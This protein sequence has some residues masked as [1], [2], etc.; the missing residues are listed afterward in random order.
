LVD[1]VPQTL[2]LKSI[3]TEFLKH[4]EIVVRRRTAYEL[5]RAEEREHILLGLVIALDNIDR[6]IK[7]IRASKTVDDARTNLMKEFKLSEL[8]ANAILEMRLQKLAGLERQKVEEELKE[9]QAFIKEMKAILASATK[10]LNIVKTELEDVKNKYGDDRRTKVI[11]G[12]VKIL[13]VEDLVADEENALVLTAGG[14]IKRTNPDEYKRQKRGGVGVVDLDTK[15]ED[16]VTNFLTTSTHSDL[17]FFTDKGKAY[18]IKMFDIPEGKRATRGKSIMNFISLS[19]DEKV[20]SILAMPKETKKIEGSLFMITEN[21]TTK[22]VAAKS[23]QDVRSSGIIAIK[24]APTDRLISVALVEKGED[25]SIVTREGQAIRFKES[26]VREMGRG[27]GGVRGIKLSGDTV[28]G[29]HVIKPAWKDAHLL[30]ISGNGY[31][32]RTE[33]TEYKVQGRGGSGILTSKVTPKTGK[34]IASQVV[35]DQEEVIAISKKSQVV[36]VDLKEIPV[37]GRQTQGVR[38]MKLREGDTIASLICL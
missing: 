10:I 28:I 25:V 30:V 5:A 4:R 8:Q 21:G 34:V 37:L 13:S 36:R 9:V 23:F 19:D 14:Y 6:V 29:A 26:T 3:L 1:G 31:G 35:T 33:L 18:Q 16:F 15:E 38:I 11:K 7:I 27:A 32:K 17:L 20:T 24:L 2:S 12:G 22:K